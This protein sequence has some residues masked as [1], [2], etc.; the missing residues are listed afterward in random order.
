MKHLTE[1]DIESVA[2]DLFSGLGY[3]TLFGP[4]IAPDMPSA[5][6]TDYRQV[7]LET[8]LLQ[9]L[10]RLNPQVQYDAIQEALRKLTR[11]DLPS[12]IAN[13]HAIHKYL[14]EGVPVEYQRR[15]GSMGGDL[16]R[17]LDYDSVD[18][19]EFLAV[20]QF[21]VV[22]N[23]HERRPDVVIFVNGLPLAVLE[24]KNA[25]AE[26]ATIW[27]AY[28]QLQT[29]K[30]QI[31]SLFAYNEA[32]VISDGIQARIGTLTAN[33]ERF[34]PWRTIEGEQLADTMLPQL[35]V[36]LEGV[37]DRR[38]FLD[39][40]RYFIVFEEV[41]GGDFIKKMAGYHQYHAVNVPLQ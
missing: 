20:N 13:N 26:E 3:Q 34:M 33:K 4:D 36:V 19:N 31:P 29:Y 17:V 21:T 1:S 39:L 7:V 35:Q 15:D 22:E 12:L 5:E 37:F 8:R 24:L 41:P 25:V 38:R 14:V 30:E 23:Q 11:P 9:A 32:L 18:N 10:Q 28:N 2:L 27:A 6:R 40:I 16:V